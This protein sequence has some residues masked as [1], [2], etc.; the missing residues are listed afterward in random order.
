MISLFPARYLPP[1]Q[2]SGSDEE[3]DASDEG[4]DADDEN[5][6]AGDDTDGTDDDTEDDTEDDTGPLAAYLEKSRDMR[7]AFLGEFSDDEV[8]EMWQIHNFMDFASGCARNAAAP[9]PGI[10]DRG[11]I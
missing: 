3:S 4:D 9:S 10:S 1:P 7:N 5:D 8:A 2:T 11:S 6:E